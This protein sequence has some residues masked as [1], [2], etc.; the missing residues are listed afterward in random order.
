M[1]PDF[2]A[3]MSRK[4]HKGLGDY[5][6]VPR[7]HRRGARKYEVGDKHRTKLGAMKAMVSMFA[8]GEY[9][10]CDVIRCQNFPSYYGPSLVCEVSESHGGLE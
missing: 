9:N 2:E 6:F 7:A 1:N 5:F 3:F 4:L 10:R 8:T